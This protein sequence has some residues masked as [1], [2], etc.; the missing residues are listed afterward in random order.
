MRV[1]MWG[2]LT[3]E[4]LQMLHLVECEACGTRASF[5]EKEGK[6]VRLDGDNHV[7]FRCPLCCREIFSRSK[8]HAWSPTFDQNPAEARSE[9]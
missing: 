8:T 1:V 2:A 9:V 4:I 3:P 7:A 5:H 6:G